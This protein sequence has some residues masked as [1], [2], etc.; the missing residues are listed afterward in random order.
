MRRATRFLV[1]LALGSIATLVLA[2]A[3]KLIY[4]HYH[5]EQ[6]TIATAAKGGEYH[7][8]GQA[9][10][11]VMTRHYPRLRVQV[12]ET[13]GSRENVQLLA[14]N[15][16]QLAIA[17]SDTPKASSAQAIAALFPEVFYLIAARGSQIQAVTD[18]R[19]KRIALMPKESGSYKFFWQLIGHYGLSEKD[20][21]ATALPPDLAYTQFRQ[22]QVDAV[23]RSIALGN[24][25]VRE[26]IQSTQATLVPID[27]VAALQL[28]LPYLTAI[29]IPKGTYQGNPATP[30]QNLPS[31]SVQA[32][33]LTNAGVDSDIIYQ[34]TG[35]LYEYRNELADLTPRAATISPP[36]AGVGLGLP[37]H[38]GAQAYYHRDQPG[39]L[40]QYAEVMGF[41][42]SVSLLLASTLWNLRS[43]FNMHR[44]NRVD[45]YN[46]QLLELIEQ[47]DGIEDL[48]QLKS[49]Q[50]Q[51]SD[52]FRT[53]ITDLDED[54]I[55]PQTFQAFSIPWEVAISSI[56]HRETVLM[57][58]QH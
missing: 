5:V 21:K 9:L 45:A 6:L 8:F 4:T 11:Q 40:E 26:L 23:F 44:K 3:G 38:P 24:Q 43:R 53:V 13:S 25:G 57:Q 41:L 17:Q 33:L 10:S 31:A 1:P 42:L 32:I 52:L 51:L 58:L 54:R 7:A 46:L 19:G 49:I 47:I 20:V 2:L 22:R 48:E 16:V 34:I 18:L 39:F 35:S 14:A 29:D 50:H 36:A 37:L 15:K 56:R 28:S 12:L 55:S 27:Q 30:P